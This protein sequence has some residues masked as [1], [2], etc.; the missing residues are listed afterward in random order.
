MK[1][2]D[3]NWEKN[4]SR[5]CLEELDI[6]LLNGPLET[7]QERVDNYFN[8]INK[9]EYEELYLTTDVYYDNAVIYLY[10][11]RL[12]TDKEFQKRIKHQEKV[13]EQYN[14]SKKKQEEKERKEY[15][16]LKKKYEG[17]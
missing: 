12:E 4:F 6:E 14:K 3:F 13:L 5:H 1:R 15:E 16:R 11:T 10:G 7:L 9:D 2:K 17:T 8:H